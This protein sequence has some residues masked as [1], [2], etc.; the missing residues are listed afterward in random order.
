MT[1]H[2]EN[3]PS[4]DCYCDA[5]KGESTKTKT[6][7]ASI[8]VCEQKYIKEAP[9]PLCLEKEKNIFGKKSMHD[10]ESSLE[11]SGKRLL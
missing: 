3:Q 6:N 10:S 1:G 9:L 4:N 11:I 8:A 5:E 2:G 7:D